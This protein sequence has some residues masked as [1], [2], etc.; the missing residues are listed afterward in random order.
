MTYVEVKNVKGT[1]NNQPPDGYSSWLD[2]WEKKKGMKADSCK[3]F[4][5]S[6]SPDVG[7]HV[8]KVNEGSTEYILPMC[9]SCNNES[10]DEIFNV[11]DSD[12][13]PVA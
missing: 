10:E 6:G 12:L 7:G 5:C 8:I 4:D 3:V 13:V 1:A 11:L 2:F 9:Y